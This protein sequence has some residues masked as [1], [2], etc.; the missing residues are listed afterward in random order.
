M[1]QEETESSAVQ[2][3]R[4]ALAA[5][6]ASSL[7]HAASRLREGGQGGQSDD[8]ERARDEAA[9]GVQ[10]VAGAFAWL[11]QPALEALARLMQAQLQ[12]ADLVEPTRPAQLAEAVLALQRCLAHALECARQ[13]REPRALHLLPC[14]RQIAAL[15]HAVDASPSVLL[16][17]Q[18]TDEVL[19]PLALLLPSLPP[20][21]PTSL[22][23]ATPLAAHLPDSLADAERSL[24]ACLRAEGAAMS[25]EAARAFG[26][27]VGVAAAESLQDG[28]RACWLALHAY[29]QEWGESAD[30][31]PSA[32]DKRILAATLRALRHRHSAD[33]RTVLEPLAREVLLA[34]SARP[35]LTAAGRRVA[36]LFRLEE[37]LGA[38]AAG[39]DDSPQ[40]EAALAEFAAGLAYRIAALECDAANISDAAFWQALADAAATAP[41]TAALADPLAR[42]AARSQQMQELTQRE[43]LAALLVELHAWSAEGGGSA[44]TL[45]GIIDLTGAAEPAVAG[46]ALHRRRQVCGA[47]QRLA[48]LCIA[49]RAELDAAEPPLEAAWQGGDCIRAVQAAADA[50]AEVAGALAVAGQHEACDA[51]NTLRETLA[52]SLGGDPCAALPALAAEWVRVAAEVAMLPL[53]P[54]ADAYGTMPADDSPADHADEASQRLRTIF[55]DEAAG[56]LGKLHGLALQCD[57]AALQAA[58]RAAHTLAGCSATVGQPAMASV[59]LALETHLMAGGWRPGNTLMAD[60][61]ATLDRMLAEFCETGRCDAPVELLACLRAAPS[62]TPCPGS[63][64]APDTGMLAQAGEAPGSASNASDHGDAGDAAA[65]RIEVFESYAS[66]IPAEP[67]FELAARAG[68][69]ANGAVAA[70]S[71]ASDQTLFPAAPTMASL[72]GAQPADEL[73]STELLATF[74]DEAA[75]LLPQLEQVL[76]AWQQHPDDSDLPRQLLRLLH[77]LKGSARMAGRHALGAAFHQAEADIT[78]LAQQS[79]EAVVRALPALLACIDGWLQGSMPA[80][81]LAWPDALSASAAGDTTANTATEPADAMARVAGPAQDERSVPPVRAPRRPAPRS[82]APVESVP[83]LRISTARLAR[84]ADA[85]AALWVGNAG[86][87]DAAQDQRLAVTSLSDDLARLRA[88]LREL[89]I[90]A[91]SRIVAQAVS[92]CDAGFDPLEFDR[93][94]RLNELTRLMAESLADLAGTQRG[95]ARQVERLA[96]AASAQARDLRRF[97]LDLQAMRAQPLRALEPRL[98]HLLRQAA[99]E[100][101]CEAALALV[102]GDVEIE[103]SMLDRLAGPLSH[104]LRNAVV[105]GIEAPGQREALGKPRTGTVTLGAALAGSEL[106]LWLHDDGR[107]IDLACVHSR[108]VAAGLLRADDE[109]AD[110]ALAALIF[111]PGF[112]TAS[113]V[114]ALAGRG[115]GMDAVRAELQALGGRIAVDSIA[116]QGCRFTLTLPVALASLPVLLATAGTRRIALPAAQIVQVV[117]PHAGQIERDAGRGQI[118]WRECRLDLRHL[119]EAIGEPCRLP[120]SEADR[121]PVVIV[122]DGERRLAWQLDVVHG[123]RELMLRHPGPQLGT[124][125]GLAGATL[126]GDGSIALILDPFRLPDTR[127]AAAAPAPERPLVLVVDDSLTVRRASQR[128]LERHGYAV[129]L[130]RDGLEALERLVERRPAVVLLDIEMPRMDGFELLAAL[131]ADAALR[132]LPVVMITS[133]IAGRH[134][135]RAQQLGVSGYLGKPFDEDTLLALLAGLHG[136]AQLAA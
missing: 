77:T 124:V 29:L 119:G 84:V 131:R 62:G 58:R 31:E 117:Q 56:H 47:R 70:A 37:Q 121:L 87:A 100:A 4:Q 102:G 99:Q 89:E 65:G 98:R 57:R 125:P 107:G 28:E 45:G 68:G 16:S 126:R 9:Q 7:T 113:E 76:Q 55:I 115:I 122:E 13:Q 74:G 46:L 82:A 63:E 11:Q 96:S 97:G 22:S 134:R 32:A 135:E 3:A 78:A 44:A 114:T 64:G 48:Q 88:Q 106:R 30:S 10:Q 34:L 18:L 69:E 120:A 72:A 52:A 71:P 128:L 5:A 15:G 127:S 36:R 86:I 49:I 1:R 85:A 103:R 60:A 23:I 67:A 130:A 118:V 108:A 24:L 54:D 21:L 94:T 90:E 101:G 19:P 123:Q 40:R 129:A 112:S 95:L 75:D 26:E 6:I 104:L 91:E 110:G 33:L 93:Y 42:L 25:G 20:A 14:W 2:A 109:P 133:R 83:Q 51:A 105:H 35:L 111:A 132:T 39:A 92:E 43:L 59:A 53:R 17:L 38:Q 8:G 27:A 80:A 81:P 79:A 66:V 116:G 61:L 50:L 73:S 136:G 41:C 12:V